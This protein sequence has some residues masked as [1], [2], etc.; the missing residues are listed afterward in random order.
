MCFGRAWRSY[1]RR[2]LEWCR[3]GKL[4]AHGQKGC[5]SRCYLKSKANGIASRPGEIAYWGD[6]WI[7]DLVSFLNPDERIQQAWSGSHLKP[8]RRLHA[9]ESGWNSGYCFERGSPRSWAIAGVIWWKWQQEVVVCSSW[10]VPGECFFL[11]PFPPVFF[12]ENFPGSVVLSWILII[13]YGSAIRSCSVK[14]VFCFHIRLG[15]RPYITLKK[16]S[17]SD[18]SITRI[19]VTTLRLWHG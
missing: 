17:H 1:E 15:L 12:L 9:Q 5:V 14:T 2:S 11:C 16:N 4:C 13:L 18:R 3:I 7:K 10:H 6:R 19:Q 8:W